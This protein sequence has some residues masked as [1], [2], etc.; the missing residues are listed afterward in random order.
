MR[1]WADRWKVTFEPSKCKA[2][3]ISRK[4]NPTRLGLQFGTYRIGWQGGAGDPGSHNWQQAD[5]WA[6]HISNISSRAGQRLGALRRVASKRDVRDRATVYKAQVRSV[7]E[8]A[9]LSWMSAS[10]TTLGLL[11]LI[12]RKALRI[13]GTSEVEARTKLNITSLHQRRQVAGGNCPI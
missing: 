9:S 6:K 10:P 7:M 11:D 1:I 13:I 3:T 4:R 8:Y 12:Q 5:T 2:M